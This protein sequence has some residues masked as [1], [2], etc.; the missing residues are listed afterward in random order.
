[1][2]LGASIQNA[3]TNFESE[4]AGG[5]HLRLELSNNK[6]NQPMN[7]NWTKL[8]P[9]LLLGIGMAATPSQAAPPATAQGLISGK[10]FNDISG[11]AISGLTNH[12]KFPNRPDALHFFPYFEWNATGDIFAP[13]GDFSNNYGGQI[14]G[15]FYPP[16]NGDY[17]FWLAADDNAVLYLS[18]DANPANKKLIAQETAYSN[19]RQYLESAGNSNLASKDSSQF[20]AT[21]WPTTDPN[22]GGARI[23]L[24]AGRPYYIEALFKEGGGG[25]HLS[26]A[27][28]DPGFMIDTTSPIP[29]E[30]LSSDRTN[31]PV[32]IAVQPQSQ[33]VSEREAVSFSFMPDGTPPYTI[34]WR[35]NGEDILDATN[36]T[37]TVSS[38]SMADNNAKYS[39][40]VEGAQGTVTSQDAT[41]TVTADTAAPAILLAK[42]SPDRTQVVLTF[43]EPLDPASAATAANYQINTTTGSLNVTGAELSSN[44]TQVTLTTAQQALG[45]KYS[46]LVSNLKDTA[47]TPNTIAANSKVVFFPPGKVV[48]QNGFIVFE[49][50]NY[51]RNL[52]GLWVRDTARGTPSGGASVV[53]PNGAGGSENA[54]RLEYDVEFKQAGTYKVWYRASGDNGNDD[55]SWFHLDGQRPAERADGNQAS[56]SGFSGLMNFDWRSDSQDGPDPFTVEIAAPGT[57]VV[58]LARREDGSFFDKFI[59]TTDMAFTP[60]GFGPPETREGAPG[61]PTVALTAPTGGQVIAG[62]ANVNLAANAAGASTLEI[63]RVDY[64]ANGNVVAQA[65]ASPFSATWTNAPAGVY[66][67]RAVAYDEIG[68]STI[69][70]S[71]VITVGTPPPQALLVVGGPSVPTL[72]PSDAGLKARLEAKGWQ[73]TSVPAPN[74][75]TADGEGKQL[76]IVSSTVSSGDVAAKFQNSAAPA[77]TWEQALQDDFLMTLN[78]DGTDR[79]T[80]TNQ[81]QLNIVKADHPLAGG[82]TTGV[83][84]VTTAAQSYSWGVPNANAVVIATVADN[85]ARALVYGYEKGASLVNGTPAP[86]RRVMLFMGDDGFA[87]FTEDA[88]KLF[89]AAITWA[90]G[91]DPQAPQG[92][93][94]AWISFHPADDTPSTDAATAGFTRAADAAYTDLLRTNGY[95]VT[96]FITSGTPDTNVLNTFDLVIISRSVPSGDY[97]DPPE[98]AAW[99]GITAPTM[100]LGGYVI[101]QNRL[102]L[103]TGNNIPDT[104]GPVKLTVNDPNHP[105]FSGIALDANKTMVNNYADIVTF[106]GTPQRGISV[107]TDPVAGNGEVLATIGTEGDPAFG[108]AVIAEWEA[109]ATL[110]N[111]AANIL[112]G[113]RLLFLTGSREANGLTSQGAGIL[114]LSA[115]GAKMFLN[116]VEYLTAGSTVEPATLSVAR[117][118]GG[119]ITIQWTGTGT[120]E[121]ADSVMGPWTAVGNAS[122]P[123]TAPT[124]GAARFY[125]L[126]Q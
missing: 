98:T 4:G 45:T 49:A 27:V 15:Y 32:A 76:I 94:I 57:Y 79:G 107:V 119:N 55:S 30:Y 121:S 52:D 100:I 114:D 104:A 110:A 81:T 34:Q 83:K 113:P 11:T 85:P 6:P 12:V 109:G 78:T 25:D 43:S 65:T 50:E 9:A 60:T 28:Q 35:K 8:L 23:T 47:A 31:G 105:I 48:E 40:R 112:G 116:A 126:R 75:T 67:V 29:G 59:L 61:L 123:F 90:S 93:N 77:I 46:V 122:S 51:D 2:C 69:S 117:A 22:V 88:L 58:G 106:N 72:N 56:M 16:A 87:A 70:D 19:K 74:S 36:L 26:V 62:G 20:A 96:R 38:A 42:G 39:V 41:L 66:A 111:T 95:N 102:G 44:G 13:P 115:D 3:L 71:V 24:Q 53:N 7:R 1:M 14:I 125:R 68:Q 89:D 101:R 80:L 54:T 37:Y 84:T 103:M 108:G 92:A 97:Q 21:Q 124:S 10:A 5:A 73:V 86:A 91:I 64:T 17:V 33:T 99:N 18:T 63:A 82:L 118:A 120:L